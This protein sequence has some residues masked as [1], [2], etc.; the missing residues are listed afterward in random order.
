VFKLVLYSLNSTVMPRKSKSAMSRIQN[1]GS[2]AKKSPVTIEDVEDE[3]EVVPYNRSPSYS[4]PTT[5]TDLEDHSLEPNIVEME[6]NMLVC[7]DDVPLIQI[8]RYGAQYLNVDSR[9]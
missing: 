5:Q 2:N 7:L 4:D 8:I 6:K 3:G 9:N 1:L